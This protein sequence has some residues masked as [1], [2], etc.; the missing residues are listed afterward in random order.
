MCLIEHP[1]TAVSETVNKKPR[2]LHQPTVFPSA[3]TRY[4]SCMNET[5]SVW[6][7]NNLHRQLHTHYLPHYSG[8]LVTK[9]HQQLYIFHQLKPPVQ[10]CVMLPQIEHNLV[11]FSYLSTH[12]LSQIASPDLLVLFND[13]TCINGLIP[14]CSYHVELS[15]WLQDE[16]L[17]LFLTEL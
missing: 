3:C 4:C 9:M 12:Y 5:R 13:I 2:E 16:L 10:C 15:S 1:V 11:T 14:I 7:M 6:N 17:E 8:V